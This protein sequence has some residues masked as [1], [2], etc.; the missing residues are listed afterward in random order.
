MTKTLQR[1]M[2]RTVSAKRQQL[3]AIRAEIEDLLDYLDVV[4]TRARDVGQPRLSHA[5]TKGV[6]PN[7]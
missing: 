4:E 2:A 3:V 7:E 5:E 1:E 6:L